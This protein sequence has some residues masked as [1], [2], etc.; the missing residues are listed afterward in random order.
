MIAR[1]SEESGVLCLGAEGK[2]KY[3]LIGGWQQKLAWLPCNHSHEE[4]KVN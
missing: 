3:L 2:N 1:C 4:K